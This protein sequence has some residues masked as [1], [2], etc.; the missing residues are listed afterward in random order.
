[1]GGLKGFWTD[2]RRGLEDA[3]L[4]ATERI[5]ELRQR[6][7]DE[8]K[9]EAGGTHDEELTALSGE[10]YRRRTTIRLGTRGG[11]EE[12]RIK[13]QVM[14]PSRYGALNPLAEIVILATADGAMVG[15]YTMASEGNDPRRY[16]FP[17][18]R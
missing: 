17:G 12:L 5:H 9:G 16:R 18:E 7:Y 13:V 15:D 14:R 1:M 2:R 3:R 8:L 10:R 4:L 6:P 11:S